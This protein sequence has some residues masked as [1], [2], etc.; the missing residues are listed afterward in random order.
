MTLI[1]NRKNNEVSRKYFSHDKKNVIKNIGKD[2]LL[3][4]LEKKNPLLAF[5]FLTEEKSEGKLVDFA[6]PK[7]KV[8]AFYVVGL[9]KKWCQEKLSYGL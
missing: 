7:E 4:S 9:G 3:K 8:E 1:N 2:S 6:L 5:Q